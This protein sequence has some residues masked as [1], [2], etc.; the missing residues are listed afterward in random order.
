MNVE[1]NVPTALRLRPH[2]AIW[3]DM[4]IV[5]AWNADCTTAV[6]GGTE[7]QWRRELG[8]SLRSRTDPPR[9]SV[10]A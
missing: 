10:P 7:G 2:T 6:S 1:L 3:M 8:H 9:L 4:S 5:H